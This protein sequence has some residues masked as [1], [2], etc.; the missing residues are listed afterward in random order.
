METVLLEAV[1]RDSAERPQRIRSTSYIPAIFYGVGEKNR[2][3][4]V[5]ERHFL[6][7]FRLAG[8]NTIVDLEIDDGSM[9]KKVL[10]HR[11]SRDP[12]SD[13][14]IHVD[15]MNVSMQRAIT[16]HIPL[17]FVGTAPAVKDLGGILNTAKSSL[18]VRCLPGDL[19]H[20]I[21]VDISGLQDFHTA[22]HI[23]EVKVPE[24]LEVLDN[25]DDVVVNVVAPKA[26]VVE[27]APAPTEAPVEG[28]EQAEK[29][30]EENETKE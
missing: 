5:A 7:V 18:N 13:R 19:V 12:V 3:L 11:I 1:T 8:E 26:E 9:K 17:E 27:E 10:V 23:N 14:I 28:V 24:K 15:F 25:P 16:T 20:S 4:K 29:A 21:K 22:I 6:K 30:K 2:L